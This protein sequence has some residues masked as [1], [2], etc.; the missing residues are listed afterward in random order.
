M[1]L[2]K[3]NVLSLETDVKYLGFTV[4]VSILYFSIVNFHVLSY[5]TM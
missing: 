5:T 3:H 2:L 1:N 4:A